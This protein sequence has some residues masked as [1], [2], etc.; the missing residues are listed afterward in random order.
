MSTGTRRQHPRERRHSRHGVSVS[1]P[2]GPTTTCAEDAPSARPVIDHGRCEAK[3]DC[4]NVCPYDVFE[5]RTIDHDDYQALGFLGR[6]RSVAH[7]RQ[8]SYPVRADACHACGLCV[9]ACPEQAI[10]LLHLAR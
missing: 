9:K 8:T 3:R 5:V 1:T 7:G 2:P 4:V 6:L 10:T